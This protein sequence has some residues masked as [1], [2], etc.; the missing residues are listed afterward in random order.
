MIR[1]FVFR[2][3][4]ALLLIAS[5][6]IFP[7]LLLWEGGRVSWQD[8]IEMYQGVYRSLLRGYL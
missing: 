7:A 6:L 1:R 4:M 5:P 3:L 8:L 2:L